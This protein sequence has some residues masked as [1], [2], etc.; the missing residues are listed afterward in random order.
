[1]SVS[2]REGGRGNPQTSTKVCIV[3][4]L[5]R[6]PECRGVNKFVLD[7][8]HPRKYSQCQVCRSH[9]PTGG[10]QVIMLNNDLSRSIF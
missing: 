6:C 7:Y 10:Y 1:M 3:Q 2:K 5:C 9:I 4:L 8:N